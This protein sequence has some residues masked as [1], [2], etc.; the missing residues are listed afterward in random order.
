MVCC[1]AKKMIMDYSV[2][3]TQGFLFLHQRDVIQGVRDKNFTSLKDWHR[4]ALER[5][6][7]HHDQENDLERLQWDLLVTDVTSKENNYFL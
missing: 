1:P 4:R 3:P 6:D 2:K 7:S 5:H